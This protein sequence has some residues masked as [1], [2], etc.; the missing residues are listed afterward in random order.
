MAEVVTDDPAVILGE[1]R[2]LVDARLERCAE[3]MEGSVPGV[4]GE[5]LGYALRSPGKRVRPALLLASYRA[6]GGEG[7]A[8]AGIATAVEIVHTYSLVHDD[9]PCMDD[10]QLRRGRP[11]THVAFDVATASRVG[12]ALVPVA[13]EELSQ[14]ALEL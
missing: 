10:D 1:A 6:A 3:R 14:S 4:L 5:A 7:S 9:L 2:A 11:T 13:A 12:F 8:I